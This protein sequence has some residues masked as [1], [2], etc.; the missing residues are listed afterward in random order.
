ML[1]VF[2]VKTVL[3]KLILWV[4][5]FL[6]SYEFSVPTGFWRVMDVCL[7]A[8]AY[9]DRIF[10]TSGCIFRSSCVRKTVS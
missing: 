4:F 7:E 3:Q 1:T 5:F 10:Q 9:V 2:L 6:F 8:I